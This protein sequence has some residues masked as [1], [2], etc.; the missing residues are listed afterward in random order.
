MST[1]ATPESTNSVPRLCGRGCGKP[2]HAG[3]CSKPSPT[4]GAANDSSAGTTKA[5]AS[6]TQKR[7]PA[8]VGPRYQVTGLPS[9]PATSRS[10]WERSRVDPYGRPVGPEEV[11][12][13]D[14][15]TAQVVV[16]SLKRAFFP[17]TSPASPEDTQH[18]RP[19]Q[20]LPPSLSEERALRL[21]HKY[22]SDL[23][24]CVHR[25]TSIIGGGV[26][27]VRYAH[28]LSKKPAPTRSPAAQRRS[29]QAA[30]ALTAADAEGTP[31]NKPPGQPTKGVKP[32][33]RPPNTA[34]STAA[35][36]AIVDPTTWMRWSRDTMKLLKSGNLITFSELVAL[37]V[38]GKDLL[39][40]TGG[41]NLTEKTLGYMNQVHAALDA[42][43][44]RVRRVRFGVVQCHDACSG[45]NPVALAQFDAQLENLRAVPVHID[46]LKYFERMSRVAHEW[47]DDTIKVL[48]HNR[49]SL[50]RKSVNLPVESVAQEQTNSAR[51]SSRRSR[52]RSKPRPGKNGNFGSSSASDRNQ[53]PLLSGSVV[54]DLLRTARDIPFD[55]RARHHSLS[56]L[57]ARLDLLAVEVKDLALPDPL[58]HDPYDNASSKPSIDR[59]ESVLEKVFRE[60]FAPDGTSTLQNSL[61]AAKAWIASSSPACTQKLRVKHV[62]EMIAAA[63]KIG[64]D[65]S[66]HQ[67]RLNEL[68]DKAQGWLARVHEVL[69]SLHSIRHKPTRQTVM[70]AVPSVAVTKPTLKQLDTLLA[71]EAHMPVDLASKRSKKTQAVFDA[72][73]TAR[74][75]L[76]NFQLVVQEQISV[77]SDGETAA[78]VVAKIMKEAQNLLVDAEDIPVEIPE[79][80]EIFMNLKL[81]EW[82]VKSDAL[83]RSTEQ[84]TDSATS[85]KLNVDECQAMVTELNGLLREACSNSR[86]RSI[87]KSEVSGATRLIKIVSDF[88][89]W[90]KRCNQL[91][92]SSRI[93]S[94]EDWEAVIN[95]GHQLPVDV[96]K[97][98]AK[99]VSRVEAAKVWLAKASALVQ[100]RS[101]GPSNDSPVTETPKVGVWTLK[102][103][104]N[105]LR[106]SSA[107]ASDA[108][109]VYDQVSHV[110]DMLAAWTASTKAVL[111]TKCTA[112]VGQEVRCVDDPTTY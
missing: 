29:S 12:S 106:S 96:C 33:S 1:G 100:P 76:E 44:S 37:E 64:V 20:S 63:D 25:L 52:A 111:D 35:S 81:R 70:G 11:W 71:E 21:F 55:I 4:S 6:S 59:I 31:S 92:A 2:P 97:P 8:N 104:K 56:K 91:L 23:D 112:K 15:E 61:R 3:K 36:A 9:E 22:D 14:P 95:D 60:G 53:V 90:Q 65:L 87:K 46:E 58:L 82:S 75:W 80:R 62:R 88:T 107:V 85:T 99:L 13:G 7:R 83:L 34:N 17:D 28:L 94:I 50:S 69:P 86:E 48:D 5:T 39:K 78:S 89:R 93:S 68:V 98:I 84:Q 49:K 77:D 16:Q 109:R 105:L 26:Q 73:D 108:N 74:D 102:Q 10:V 30:A 27:G 66:A 103:L 47:Y 24:L 67:R 42:I 72:A 57:Q 51:S 110:V 45:T 101:S 43:R 79:S 40:S 19:Q 32:P 41:V 38:Q 18:Q 54:R